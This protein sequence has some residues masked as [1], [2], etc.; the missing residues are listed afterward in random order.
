MSMHLEFEPYG[1]YMGW[2]IKK[3]DPDTVSDGK[4]WEA[5]TDDG[6]TYT[7]LEQFAGTLKELKQKIKVTSLIYHMTREQLWKVTDIVYDMEYNPAHPDDT[8][9]A[10]VWDVFYTY[11][12]ATQLEIIEKAKA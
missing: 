11:D 8:F 9:N 1:W 4:Y 10:G 6:N 3:N 2:A 7:I 5:F 12:H